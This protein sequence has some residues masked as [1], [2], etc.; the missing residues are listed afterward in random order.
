MSNSKETASLVLRT[1]DIFSDD[2]TTANLNLIINNQVGNIAQNGQYIVFKN[3]N[4]S[5]LL[6]D[7]LDKYTKF[8]LNLSSYSARAPFTQ[9]LE[10]DMTFYMSGFNW[11]NQCYNLKTGSITNKAVVFTSKLYENTNGYDVP[12][13]SNTLTFHKPTSGNFDIIIEL[14][15]GLG[16]YLDTVVNHQTFIFDIV[17]CD[18]Y[19]TN[20]RAVINNVEIPINNINNRLNIHNKII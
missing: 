14:R 10:S 2:I 18:G 3:V 16:N 4:P 6:G 1:S 12:I 11:S 8:N 15:D 19:Q 7:M 5:L 13:N 9:N 17:G 20:E